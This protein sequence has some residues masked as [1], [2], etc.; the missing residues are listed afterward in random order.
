MGF[1]EGFPRLTGIGCALTH[2]FTPVPAV[3]H[4][5]LAHLLHRDALRQTGLARPRLPCSADAYSGVASLGA[6][7]R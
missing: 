3:F 5:F 4:R 1:L 2:R 7:W 6:S